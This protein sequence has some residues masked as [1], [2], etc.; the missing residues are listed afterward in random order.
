MTGIT[1]WKDL[2]RIT[3]YPT[4]CTIVVDTVHAVVSHTHVTA[5]TAISGMVVN[6]G[7]KLCKTFVSITMS[8]SKFKSDIFLFDIKIWLHF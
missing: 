5:M 7:E 4:A 3:T 1:S 8:L 6:T 2:K